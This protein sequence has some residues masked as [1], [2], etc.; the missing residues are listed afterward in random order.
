MPRP[1]RTL[2]NSRG[3]DWLTVN[4]RRASRLA[5]HK[6]LVR[7]PAEI[8]FRFRQE[9]ANLYLWKLP[10]PLVREPGRPHLPD[11]GP[12]IERLRPA[13]FSA[14][15]LRLADE[16]LR[17][18]IPIFGDVLDTGP[19][20]HWRRD[21]V[22]Q[23]ETST[24]YFRRVRYLDFSLSGDHKY[25]WELS[26]HQHL[27]ILAQAFRFSGE[28]AYLEEAQ[29]QVESWLAAN[30]YLRGINWASALE[31]AFRALSWIWLDHLA[32]EWLPAAFRQTLV[33]ALYRHGC[34]LEQNLSVYFS[35][36]THLIGEAAALGS[37]GTLYPEFPRSGRWQARA[38][39]VLEE[40]METQVLADGSHFE[41]SAYYH[42]YALDFFLW[43]AVRAKT[44]VRF[45]DKLGRM[46]D[47][48]EALLGPAGRLPQIGD[49]D[50]GRVFHPYGARTAFGP[51]TLATCAVRLD[52]PELIRSAED[53]AEQAAWWIGEPALDCPP[54]P[55]PEASSRLF[56]NAG[57]AIMT[58]G[59]VQIVAKAGG[60]GA[61]SAG[62]SHSDVLSFVCRRGTRELLID[63]GTYT[64]I[65]GDEWRER[66]RGSAAHNT[67]RIDGANQAQAA[68]PFRWHGLPEVGVGD[69]VSTPER[70]ALDAHCRYAGFLHRRRWVFLKPDLLLVLDQVEGPAGE[71]LVEQFW[72]AGDSPDAFDY[73]AFSHPAD[74]F[75]AWR[76]RVFG[77]KEPAAARCVTY[78]GALPVTLAAAISF[79]E[80]LEHLALD[81]QGEIYTFRVKLRGGQAVEYQIQ[82]RTK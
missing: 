45:R 41:Q 68:G 10:P 16:V 27:V 37:L 57:V 26:R 22:N 65:A 52:R 48:L 70:D 67:I 12:T 18:K 80:P 9:L 2:P 17:H 73:I 77:S 33:T 64:Y 39:E 61:Q 69:W 3:S 72:H 7:R 13:A 82:P 62:H 55:R 44:S 1:R 66:F 74:F 50:G 14:E 34:F 4:I 11:P 42:L 43:H 25:I 46:A 71:H 23:A 29:R 76:S 8:A 58:A 75:P 54:A 32:G 35:P 15:V 30:P 60:F 28:L 6:D 21:Y 49:D 36:N 19:E 63:P 40:E 78:R 53:L 20:I 47:Y 31:V 59:G 5:Y 24:P 56:P 38:A 81:E 51:A 79:R